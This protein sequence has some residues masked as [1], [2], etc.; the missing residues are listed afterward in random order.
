[1]ILRGVVAA[2]VLASAT[3][4]CSSGGSA[5]VAFE[6]SDVQVVDCPD[7]APADVACLVV[8]GP[9]VAA[10][11]A[12][13]RTA[14]GTCVVWAATDGDPVVEVARRTVD[15]VPGE[16]VSWDLQVGHQDDPDLDGWTGGCDPTIEG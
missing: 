15:M 14:R 12:E 5:P 4:G 3:A 11:G 10:V 1:M 9:V 7:D 8:G 2:V 6:S 16:D 13:D